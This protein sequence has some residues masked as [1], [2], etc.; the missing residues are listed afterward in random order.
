MRPI[1]ENR[2]ATLG[3]AIVF[4]LAMT[5]I[6]LAVVSLVSLLGGGEQMQ[7]ATDAG[8]LSLA[9]SV[10]VKVAVPISD[11]GDEEQFNGVTEHTNGGSGVINLRNFNRAMAQSMLVSLNANKINQDGLDFGAASNAQKLSST[12]QIIGNRLAQQLAKPAAVQDFFNAVAKLNPTKEFGDK[13]INA[14][15]NPQVSFLERTGASNVSLSLEQI[16]DYDFSSNSSKLYKDKIS[17]W[18]T[19][20]SSASN[21]NALYLKGYVDGMTPGNSLPNSYFVPLR[22]GARPHLVPQLEFENGKKQSS[23]PNPF[24][25]SLPVPNAISIQAQSTSEQGYQGNFAACALIEPIDGAGFQASIPHGFIRLQN[26]ASSP[27]TGVAAGQKDVFVFT[28]DNPQFYP[29]DNNG[30]PLPYFTNDPAVLQAIVDANNNGKTPDCTQLSVGYMLAGDANFGLNSVSQ[31][32]CKSITGIANASAPIDNILLDTV[33]SKGNSDMGRYNNTDDRQ[34]WARPLL[35]RAYN[36]P[37]P[38]GIGSNGQSVN[39]ADIINLQMLS[40]RA[41]GNDFNPITY[42]S[43]IA[44]VPGGTRNAETSG[45]YRITSDQGVHLESTSGEGIAKGGAMWNFLSQRMFQIDP[46]WKNYSSSLDDVLKQDIVPMG[47]RAY[48]YYSESA[49]GGKGG[50]TLKNEAAAL[51]DAPWLRDFIGQT[52]DAKSP[53]NPTEVRNVYLQNDEQ[54]DV[55]GDWEFPHPYDIEGQICV[56]NWYS[57]T[58]S[59]GWNNLL[60]Q[61]NMGAINTNCCPE[62]TN[63]TTSSF[64]INYSM[65]G[66]KLTMPAG[67]SCEQGGGCSYGGPC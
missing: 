19:T 20:V 27:T 61:V 64:S 13:T 36:I 59:S 46:N 63:N 33:G 60:G 10:L 39:V 24:A 34:L 5:V 54:V 43:G 58:P 29:V 44:H 47:G 32:N 51:T 67:C 11:S 2:A 65:G 16:P 45:N 31:A 35:E 37:P 3:L 28:M 41:E 56:L 66:D 50:L 6:G 14:V 49:N 4:I 62:G 18:V 21:N 26:G 42:Q 12:V 23:A 22:P 15:G 30:T 9:R 55:S 53:S 48:I 7:R 57:F 40:A 8:N 52:A 38:Q 1:R 17:A 25:W